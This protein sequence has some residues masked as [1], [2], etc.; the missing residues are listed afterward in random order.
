MNLKN[1]LEICVSGENVE[2]FLNLCSFHDIKL[3]N[4][5]NID[6]KYYMDLS[7]E[8]FSAAFLFSLLL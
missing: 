4:I 1:I 5:T 2:R 6:N 7:P 8:D 3:S